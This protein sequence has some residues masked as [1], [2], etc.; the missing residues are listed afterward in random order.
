M[1]RSQLSA[2]PVKGDMQLNQGETIVKQ[3]KV[4][5]A[6][7][8]IAKGGMLILTNQRL[9]YEKNWNMYMGLLGMLMGPIGAK[10]EF[11]ASLKQ[12]KKFERTTFGLNKNVANIDFGDGEARRFIL[13]SSFEDWA[14][15]LKQAKK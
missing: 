12:L 4:M 6:P 1:A 2:R 13:T 7:G 3:E 5:Y 15:A 9:A 8:V 11:E 10:V 14:E